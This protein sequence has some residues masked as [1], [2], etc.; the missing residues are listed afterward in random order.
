MSHTERCHVREF[1]ARMCALEPGDVLAPLTSPV[2]S[3]Y[4]ILVLDRAPDGVLTLSYP[5]QDLRIVADPKGPFR[6]LE[7][8][9]TLVDS[10][11]NPHELIDLGT[12]V[13]KS[14]G[15]ALVS[16]FR[17]LGRWAKSF[18]VLGE[19]RIREIVD[20]DS[21]LR[22]RVDA[23]LFNDWLATPNARVAA[24]LE[25]IMGRPLTESEQA[26]A[27]ALVSCL[28]RA[29]PVVDLVIVPGDAS[30]EMPPRATH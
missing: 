3:G 15:L 5:C 23:A 4:R 11:E 10:E 25:L 14:T 18:S 17:E 28:A 13:E 6:W 12:L 20:T 1:K 9:E 16:E 27:M 7:E 8:A 26:H 22:R 2:P 29:V 21:P 30:A 19:D 24:A